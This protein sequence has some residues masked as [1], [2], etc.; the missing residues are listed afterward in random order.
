MDINH[1]ISNTMTNNGVHVA[2]APG[3]G[4]M[5]ERVAYDRY[6]DFNNDKKNEIM[7]Q[8]VNQTNEIEKYR[9]QLV[10]HIA[11]R[12]LKEK[13]YVSWMSWFDDNCQEYYITCPSDEAI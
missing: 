10:A 6:N 9:E 13:A 7:V 12:E 8:R 1:F 3:D 4:L 5:L 11:Q 2:L